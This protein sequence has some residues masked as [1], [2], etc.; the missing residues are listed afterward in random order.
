MKTLVLSKYPV[1]KTGRK[2]AKALGADYATKVPPNMIQYDRLI[3]WGSS[4]APLLDPEIEYVLN[5]ASPLR[6]MA[7]RFLMFEHL[8]KHDIPTLSLSCEYDHLP[9]IVRSPHGKWGRDI[10]VNGIVTVGRFAVEQWLAD[11]EI[12]LH[13]V[14]GVCVC[15]QIKRQKD[16]PINEPLREWH[17]RNRQHGWHLYHLH[18]D[19]AARLGINK[20]VLRT[21]AK[22]T[23]ASAQLDFGVVDFLVRCKAPEY[24]GAATPFDYR[25]LEVNTAPGLEDATLARY[26]ERLNA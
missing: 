26:V 23:I 13:I 3:R 22:K 12:R 20:D 15:M 1:G 24:D 25:V 21:I 14:N 9:H 7:N 4:Y 17:I 5:P 18:N 2:L 19:E 10:D 11:F 16:V 6:T 8:H